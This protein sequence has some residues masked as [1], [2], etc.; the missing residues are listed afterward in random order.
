MKIFRF[1]SEAGDWT[2][3]IAAIAI[4][5]IMCLAVFMRYVQGAPLQWVEE[6]LILI[7]MWM[8]M[9]GAASAMR[10]RGHV[11]IDAVT[12]FLPR[13]IQA[14]IQIF[15]DIVSIVVLV[16]LGTLGLMLAMKAGAKITPIIGIPYRY[17][18]LAMPVGCYWMAIYVVINLWRD[19]TGG[20]SATPQDGGAK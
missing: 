12:S 15:D 19:V 18:D 4:V 1:I 9:I 17:I 2:A 11:S 5:V 8:I 20:S 14:K 16:T 10:T 7:F 13:N 6:I 3:R